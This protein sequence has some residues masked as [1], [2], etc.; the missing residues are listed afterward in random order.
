M[1]LG[2]LGITRFLG[3]ARSTARKPCLAI[4]GDNPALIDH[5]VAVW[6]SQQE[7][8]TEVA[9]LEKPDI[10]DLQAALTNQSW[11]A[12]RLAVRVEGAEKLSTQELNPLCKQTTNRLLLVYRDGRKKPDESLEAPAVLCST[13]SMS[14]DAFPAYVKWLTTEGKWD[15]AALD[16]AVQVLHGHQGR[17][18]FELCKAEILAGDGKVGA[19]EFMEAVS[20]LATPTAWQ[21]TEALWSRNISK[22]LYLAD[23]IA[24][25]GEHWGLLGALSQSLLL[26]QSYHRSKAEKQSS[27]DFWIKKKVPPFIAERVTE[28][29]KVVRAQD[30]GPKLAKLAEFD[31]KFRWASSEETPAITCQMML[32]LQG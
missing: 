12:E 26:V 5:A 7:T 32:A 30:T 29:A 3:D 22:A 10:F 13:M 8:D 1:K 4:V 20:F 19:Q 2:N 21:V 17:A 31:E 23:K 25:I 28:A 6:Q 15:A 18:R 24:R 14:S 9:V 11:H 27:R 16:L